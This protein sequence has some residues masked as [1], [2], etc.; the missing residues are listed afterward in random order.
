ME[1]IALN[2]ALTLSFPDGFRRL[3]EA[4][5]NKL[6]FIEAGE[7]VCLRDEARHILVSLGYKKVGLLPRLTL[8]SVDVAKASQAR[9]AA[10]MK[11]YGY[12]QLRWQ[13]GRMDGKKA[14][15]FRYTYQAQGV[16]MAGDCCVVK[17][18]GVIYYLN[19][20]VREAGQEESFRLWEEILDAA[21]WKR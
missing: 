8:D 6:T 3:T 17:D 11:A 21:R 1:N 18:G 5:T 12:G 14:C 20:Y 9:V 10:A 15:G 4:E 13:N 7:G 2:N 19:A 16:D